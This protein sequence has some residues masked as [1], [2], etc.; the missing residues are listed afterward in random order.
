MP[1]GSTA[2]QHALS[3]LCCVV[4]VVVWPELCCA[5]FSLSLSLPI[6]QLET[7]QQNTKW[8]DGG[9][10]GGLKSL[11]LPFSSPPVSQTSH[12]FADE[13]EEEEK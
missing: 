10:G 6:S 9:G 3:D 1:Y 8:L 2:S 5:A 12:D 7:L 13:E 11:L 4:V